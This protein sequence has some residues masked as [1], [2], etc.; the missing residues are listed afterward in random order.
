MWLTFIKL[1]SVNAVKSLYTPCTPQLEV[2]ICPNSK[3][4]S[5]W[6]VGALFSEAACTGRTSTAFGNRIWLQ[7]ITIQH[8]Y[9]RRI[10]KWQGVPRA[11]LGGWKTWTREQ[12]IKHQVLIGSRHKHLQ[13]TQIVFNPHVKVSIGIKSHFKLIQLTVG[14]TSMCNQQLIITIPRAKRSE[15][16]NPL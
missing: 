9:S 2:G 14:S 8:R 6:S 7:H 16:S 13:Q 5:S 11:T 15:P 3:F 1:S 4:S 10:I 12:I